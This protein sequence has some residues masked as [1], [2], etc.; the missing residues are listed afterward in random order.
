[1]SKSYAGCVCSSVRNAVAPILEPQLFQG[2]HWCLY[3]WY[4]LSGPVTRE[5]VLLRRGRTWLR[6]D[7]SW[8]EAVSWIGAWC[9]ECGQND[10]LYAATTRDVNWMARVERDVW[11]TA[12]GYSHSG[13]HPDARDRAVIL[14]LLL[15]A[16]RK[17]VLERRFA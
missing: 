12:N 14:A 16:C 8:A 1:M 4:L 15:R 13:S 17:A 6:A 2:E 9:K 7:L 10:A 5:R 3:C 11:Q